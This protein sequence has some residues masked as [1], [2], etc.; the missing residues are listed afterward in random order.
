[1]K[2]KSKKT[3]G[4]LRRKSSGKTQIVEQAWLVGD[5]SMYGGER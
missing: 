4:K 1:M 2:N 5:G 3:E